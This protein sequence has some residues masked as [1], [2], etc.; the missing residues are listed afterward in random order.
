[1]NEITKPNW[2]FFTEWVSTL[3]VFLVCFAF[4]YNQIGKVDEKLERQGARTD[5]LYEMF[6]DLQKQMREDLCT[7]KDELILMKKEQYEFM[8]EFK[9]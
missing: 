9:Q 8:Q 3:S 1:M 4:L 5:K 2:I 7:M 6:C